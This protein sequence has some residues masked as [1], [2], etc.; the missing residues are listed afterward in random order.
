MNPYPEVVAKIAQDYLDRVKRQLRLVPAREQEEFLREIQSHVYEA[1]QQTHESEDDVARI[2]AV[3]RNLGEPADVVADRLPEAMVRSGTKR[4]VPLY[5]VSGILIA[6]L[7]IPLGIGGV[8]VVVDLL[9]ALAALVAAYYAVTGSV[10]LVGAV[11]AL[12][13]LTRIVLPSLWDRLVELGFIQFSK[14]FSDLVDQLSSADQ[15]FIMMLMAC[16]FLA[17]GWGMLKLGSRMLRGLRFLFSLA[18]DRMKRFVQGVRTKLRQDKGEGF[19]A[20]GVSA[21]NF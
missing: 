3:L 14:P 9:F 20:N 11:L 21:P 5:I 15:G 6:V 7:G 1:Y 4:K 13:G 19:P 18:F 10:L 17:T 16:V 12:M 2:L 8:A